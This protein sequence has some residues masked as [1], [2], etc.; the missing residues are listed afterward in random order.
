MRDYGNT[1]ITCHL[2]NSSVLPKKGFP[3]VF[4]GIKGSEQHTKWTLSYFSVLEA[5]IVRNYCVKLIGDPE[6]KIC[7]HGSFCCS[8]ISFF[9]NMG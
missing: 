3:I 6:R 4:H 8:T 7:E 2:V 1:H 9:F 5:S